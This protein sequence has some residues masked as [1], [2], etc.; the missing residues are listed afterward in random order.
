MDF[1]T[2]F[3]F[4]FF[5]L[6]FIF[7]IFFFIFALDSIS[8]R[9]DLPTSRRAIKVLIEII[10]EYK[11]DA[12]NFFDLGCGRGTIVLIIKK[13]LPYLSVHGVDDSSVR[14]LFSRIKALLFRRNIIFEKNDIFQVD[15]SS[16]D[17]V[18]TYLWYD[19]MPILEEKLKHELKSGAIVV[20]NTSHFST[21]M[22]IKEF[23]V[24]QDKP[25]F[26]RLFVYKK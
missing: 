19:T 8:R 24:H 25:D 21:W 23:I 11:P 15:M 2:V 10:R 17:I 6:F 4:I 13:N 14:I 12:K 16:A 26:E 9:H 5:L 18:Y 1:L 7:A 3:I 20:T 22:P